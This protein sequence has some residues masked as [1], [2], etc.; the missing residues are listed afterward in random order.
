VEFVIDSWTPEAIIG[1]AKGERF[2]SE[3]HEFRTAVKATTYHQ[4]ES[5]AIPGGWEIRV[6]VDV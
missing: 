6:F 4:F 2:D 3:R 1:H 5:H